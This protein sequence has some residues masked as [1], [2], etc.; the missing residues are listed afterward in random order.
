MITYQ[1]VVGP[2]LTGGV[3]RCLT[4]LHYVFI[5]EAIPVFRPRLVLKGTETYAQTDPFDYV[6]ITHMYT[7]TNLYTVPGFIVRSP[8]HIVIVILHLDEPISQD[9]CGVIYVVICCHPV[10]G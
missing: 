3:Q 5:A 6:L 8:L 2:D 1:E 9:G 4:E 10:G 7:H